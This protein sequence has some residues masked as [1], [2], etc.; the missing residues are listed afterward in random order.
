MFAHAIQHTLLQHE[1]QFL[2]RTIVVAPS[3]AAEQ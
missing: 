3:T 2:D 1:K